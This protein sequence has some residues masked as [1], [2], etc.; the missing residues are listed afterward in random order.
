MRNFQIV[1]C[2]FRTC[3][4]NLDKDFPIYLESSIRFSLWNVGHPVWRNGRLGSAGR[5]GGGFLSIWNL[6]P[7]LRSICASA[8]I[9]AKPTSGM[10]RWVCRF[11][12]NSRCWSARAMALIR[13]SARAWN[14]VIDNFGQHSKGCILKGL[15]VHVARD[16]F[17]VLTHPL[18]HQVFQHLA[19]TQLEFVKWVGLS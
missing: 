16:N 17:V 2:C 10:L 15:V 9:P 13:L 3:P 8:M 1:E 7:L 12:R 18:N 4:W 14:C 19:K 6:G 5:G 11:S